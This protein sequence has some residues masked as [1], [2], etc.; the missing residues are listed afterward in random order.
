[1]NIIV[2]VNLAADDSV[3]SK[4]PEEILTFFG[5]DTTK[6][7]VSVSVSQSYAPPLPQV[8]PAVTPPK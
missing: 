5:G 6:D 7:T 8:G 3:P 2:N 1:M 4:T